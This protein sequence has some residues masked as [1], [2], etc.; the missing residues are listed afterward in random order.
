[1]KKLPYTSMSL[2]W[3]SDSSSDCEPNVLYRYVQLE[4]LLVELARVTR[5]LRTQEGR[6]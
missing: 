1:M 4:T 5:E 6:R 2:P 3:R